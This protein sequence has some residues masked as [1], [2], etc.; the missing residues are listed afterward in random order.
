[1]PFLRKY[2]LSQR[3]VIFVGFLACMSYAIARAGDDN[4]SGGF[5]IS[6]TPAGF[7]PAFERYLNLG[8]LSR[9]WADKDASLLADIGLL[10]AEGERVLFRSH[11]AIS[12][13]QVLS[14]AAKIAAEK[15][16][17]K[18][19]GRLAKALEV[20]NKPD[21]AKQ[22]AASLKLG[23]VS[24]A[25]DPALAISAEK[26][27][28]E[29]FLLFRDTLE[30]IT[31]AKVVGD[32][33][34]LDIII[35]LTPQMT[36]MPESQRKY[37]IKVAT[38]ARAAL[39]GDGKALDPTA[40]SLDKLLEESRGP[41]KS[42]KEAS[43]LGVKYT[44]TPKGLRVIGLTSDR[45]VVTTKGGKLNKGDLILRV[46]TR[47]CYGRDLNLD[48]LIRTAF[49]TGNIQILVYQAE[50]RNCLTLELSSEGGAAKRMN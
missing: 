40:E 22:V 8:L 18:T 4:I 26:M 35:Q 34:S 23:S 13:D 1:M 12:A 39:P 5:W 41:G 15:K 10:L 44:T 38:E 45:A 27:A 17:T 9:A 46:G 37:L 28:P 31:A 50:T 42:G 43:S 30:S 20:H 49:E 3:I 6:G 29:I 25:P 48:A 2:L 47:A 36:R 19:L 24:R 21:L 33:E 14:M 16:D 11:K 32:G 7:D